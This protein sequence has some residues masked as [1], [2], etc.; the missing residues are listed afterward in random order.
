MSASCLCV[1]D[2]ISDTAEDRN[3]ASQRANAESA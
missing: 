3:D 1:T 2:E